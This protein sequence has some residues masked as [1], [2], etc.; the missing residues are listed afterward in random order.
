VAT[1]QTVKVS[2]LRSDLADALERLLKKDPAQLG[3]VIVEQLDVRYLQ[4]CTDKETGKQLL[5]DE[6]GFCNVHRPV[7][8]IHMKPLPTVRS[9]VLTAEMCIRSMNGPGWGLAGDDEVTITE[10][11]CESRWKGLMRESREWFEAMKKKV[12]AIENLTPEDLATV[13]R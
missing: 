2:R 4:F 1:K 9:A 7:S 10:D 13:V 8:S 3:F 11:D 6:G 12:R 5:F